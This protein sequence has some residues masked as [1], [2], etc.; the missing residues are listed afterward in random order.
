M[1]GSMVGSERSADR[2]RILRTVRTLRGALRATDRDLKDAQ[3]SGLSLDD[4]RAL[5]ALARRAERDAADAAETL[6]H[7]AAREQGRR[8]REENA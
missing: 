4:T 3:A 1:A 7:I 5:H 8:E 2:D 6:R